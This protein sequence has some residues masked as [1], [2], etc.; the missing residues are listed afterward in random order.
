MEA[1]NDSK[2]LVLEGT[3]STANVVAELTDNVELTVEQQNVDE[4][5]ILIEQDEESDEE[6]VVEVSRTST[7][8]FTLLPE[9]L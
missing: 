3:A 6:D 2:P 8:R 7:P 9:V 5:A 4:R 1:T